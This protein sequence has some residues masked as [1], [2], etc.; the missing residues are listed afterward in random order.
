MTKKKKKRL[1]YRFQKD[2]EDNA[3]VVLVVVLD[4]IT[5]ILY[6]IRVMWTVTSGYRTMNSVRLLVIIRCIVIIV[7]INI[8]NGDIGVIT[9]IQTAAIAVTV[10]II[11]VAQVNM[12][13]SQSSSRRFPC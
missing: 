6:A 9:M 3:I 12:I 1:S 4:V 11:S 5:F 13:Q 2:G 8:V 7:T 10:S